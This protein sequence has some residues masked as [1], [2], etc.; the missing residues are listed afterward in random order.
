[1]DRL[2]RMT[3]LLVLSAAFALWLQMSVVLTGRVPAGALTAAMTAGVLVVTV[4]AAPRPLKALRGLTRPTVLLACAGGL[5]AFFGAPALVAGLRMT[6]APA[7][8]IVVF[9]VSGGW[10][11]IAAVGAAVLALRERLALSAGWSLAGA[12][13]ALAGVAGVVADW[14]RPSSFSPWVRFAPREIGMLA[15]V[16]ALAHAR[17]ARTAGPAPVL[18]ALATAPALLAI[19][20]LALPAIFVQVDVTIGGTF[21]GSWTMIGAE[22]VAGWVAV[23]LAMLAMVAAHDA[24]PL[25]PIAAALAASA[26]WAW[27]LDVPT[28]VWNAS[29]SPDIQIYYGTEHGT[30]AFTSAPNAAMVGAVILGALVMLAIMVVRRASVRETLHLGHGGK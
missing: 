30:I 10:A 14:A 20:A 18:S 8:S 23:A 9:W 5:L 19:V 4:L 17:D 7:G 24:R 15:G 11:A 3:P 16:C 12:L 22:S 29:L 1:M 13:L 2:R 6:D 21:S 27:L 28:H 26:G 25:W